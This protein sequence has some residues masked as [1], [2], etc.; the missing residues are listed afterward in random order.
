MAGDVSDALITASCPAI[1]F[2]RYPSF[3]LNTKTP[4]LLPGRVRPAVPPRFGEHGP[5]HSCRDNGRTRRQLHP[6]WIS[7]VDLTG[8]VRGTLPCRGSQSG[9]HRLPEGMHPYSSRSQESHTSIRHRCLD[10]V[11]TTMSMRHVMTNRMCASAHL[12]QRSNRLAWAA[13]YLLE[14]RRNTTSGGVDGSD[15]ASS[16]TPEG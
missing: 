4:A 14:A 8:D 12:S 9:G 16:C 15:R 11:L 2:A 7:L 6:S 1:R 10:L 3:S 5:P 13:P